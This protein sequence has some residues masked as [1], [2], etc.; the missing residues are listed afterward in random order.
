MSNPA[1]IRLFHAAE[2]REYR[3]V[4]LRALEDSP[5]AFG[6]TY[7]DSVRYPDE[8]WMER[9]RRAR[10]ETDY[11][12]AAIVDGTIAGIAWARI[13]SPEYRA[14]HL[15]QMWVDP[16]YRGRGIGRALMESAISWARRQNADRMIL[17]VTCGDRPARRLYEAFGFTP[18]G[19]PE[20]VRPGSELL[21]QSM[22]LRL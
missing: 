1:T 7:E 17:E 2:W 14:A 15:Y 18:I 22:E 3:E 11:P 16:M 20:P 6:S 12:M 4:R 8:H 19:A 5:D 10:S 9:L 21:E 13:E